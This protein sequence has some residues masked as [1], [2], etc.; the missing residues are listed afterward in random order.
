MPQRI[1]LTFV[2]L[3]ED[4]PSKSTMKKLERFHLARRIN[5]RNFGR[6][7]TLTPYAG[8]Y[9]RR[10]DSELV[11]RYGLCVIDGS[12]AKI[13]GIKKYKIENGRRIPALL[14]ANPVNFGKLEIL[15]S[16][17]ALAAALFIIGNTNI[18]ETILNKFKWGPNFLVLNRNPLHEYSECKSD[19]EVK[20]VELE[21]FA[22]KESKKTG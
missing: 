6:K 19:D 1:E 21:Y 10:N 4:D 18:A 22:T 2:Y 17:E 16:V 9:I 8:S 20:S 14:A 12:W 3:R 13:E 5:G 15:S 11:S 7:V